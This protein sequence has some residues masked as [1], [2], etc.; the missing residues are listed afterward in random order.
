MIRSPSL[1]DIWAHPQ[2]DAHYEWDD[3]IVGYR[4]RAGD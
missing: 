3:E 4:R 1:E 2:L